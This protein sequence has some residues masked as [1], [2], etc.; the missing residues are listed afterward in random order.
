MT[1]LPII[2]LQIEQMKRTVSAMLSE[3]TAMLDEQVNIAL[4]RALEPE[5]ITLVIRRTVEDAVNAAVSEEIQNFFRYS[6]PGRQAI[7]EA[8]LAHLN[9]YWAARDDPEKDQQNGR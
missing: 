4:E 2:T 6:N 9:E 3:H 8:V 1:N 7:R 5:Q